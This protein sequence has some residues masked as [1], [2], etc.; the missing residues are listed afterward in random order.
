VPG[1]C[2]PLYTSTTTKSKY[3]LNTSA[4][5]YF[6][7]ETVCNNQGGHLASWN[8][9]AEQREVETFF[10]KEVRPPA[11]L[12][13]CKPASPARGIVALDARH[14][15]TSSVDCKGASCQWE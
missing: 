5:D 7:A 4:T 2:G 12:R 3:S 11:C 1:P 13:A 8:S 10:L 14:H 9:E 6:S 15:S